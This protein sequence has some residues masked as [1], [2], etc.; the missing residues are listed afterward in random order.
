MPLSKYVLEQEQKYVKKCL[1]EIN[2]QMK[3]LGADLQVEQV[4]LREN[5]KFIWENKGS[6]DPV[7]IR[8]NLMSS[9]LDFYFFDK[10]ANYFKKL[11]RLKDNPYFGRVDFREQNKK[12]YTI[13]IGITHLTKNNKNLIHDWRAPISSLFYDY[14]LGKAS[15]EAPKGTIE[16]FLTKKRQYKIKKGQ[17]IHVFDNDINV[18]DEFLQE[19]LTTTSNDKMKN[20]VNTI[21]RE[22]NEV[23]RNI[24]NKNLIVQGIAGSGK[25]S[26]ALHRIA[27]L[28]YKLDYLSSNN[29][30]IFSPNNIF[31]EYISNVLPELGE[32]NALETTFS[33]FAIKYITSYRKIESFASFIERYYT[34][35]NT[36]KKLTTFKMSDQI[37]GIIDKYVANLTKKA[38]FINDIQI[39]LSVSPK[40]ELNDLFHGRYS[41]MTIFERLELI[42]EHIC[43]AERKSQ[44]KYRKI[45]HKKLWE[46]FSMPRN[47]KVLFKGLFKSKYFIEGYGN[48]LTDKEVNDF[49]ER[50]ILYY[51]DCLLFIYLQGK[52]QT[53]PYSSVIKQIVIDEAQDYN[54]LQ[55][56]ILKKIF[57]RTSFTILGDVNQNI[58]PYYKYESL[59]ELSEIVGN[60]KYFE[61]NKTYRSSP[62]IIDYANQVLNLK[63]A[64][65]VRHSNNY[66]VLLVNSLDEYNQLKIDIKEGQKNH[67]KIAII[68]KSHEEAERL[69]NILKG[70]YPKLNYLTEHSESFNHDLVILPSYLSKGLE[71]DLV[72]L[73]TDKNN[74][75]KADEQHLYYVVI[76]RAQHQLIIYNQTVDKYR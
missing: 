37:I 39:D 50:K 76:T 33:D 10:K 31:S 48:E 38:K 17:L 75:Y 65:S 6:M 25:T 61:L 45:I 5:R 55:Y 16:G 57:P 23:I 13:Y 2:K 43:D 73:Y 21:Q 18:T 64:V 62:E 69:F 46:S 30:L 71:F 47:I 1:T 66:P 42:A 15:F 56:I 58:N 41:K 74:E 51:E 35:I 14:E 54:K 52:L 34:K 7:E 53:F 20:I 59:N 36:N 22:Q 4:N 26:V 27:F 68:T 9:D 60:A 11:Y 72:I 28:L 63:Y 29:V 8:S 19:V 24:V 70:D 32:A 49:A 12:D 40:E 44:G 3:G 67:S